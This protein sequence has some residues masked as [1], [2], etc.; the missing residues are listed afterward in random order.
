M[1]RR[2]SSTS[3]PV[4][5]GALALATAAILIV[6]GACASTGGTEDGP[7]ERRDVLTHQQI[8][9]A[10]ASN[11]LEAV[12][13]LRPEWLRVQQ[14]SFS[15]GTRVVVIENGTVLGGVEQLR[16]FTPSSVQELRFVDGD[17]AAATLVGGREGFI[18]GAIVV[19]RG[20]DS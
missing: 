8:V 4:R 5:R 17:R 16:Q 10:E 1:T 3:R 15:G 12:R 20:S 14:R 6:G 11:A 13:R 19:E 7:S 2:A 9:S 18:E